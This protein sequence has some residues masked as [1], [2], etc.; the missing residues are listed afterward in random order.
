M[1]SWNYSAF[2]DKLG[3]TIEYG[4][5]MG[6]P[7]SGKSTLAQVLKSKID[8]QIISMKGI[9]DEIRAGMKNEEGEPVD[10]ETEVPITEVEKKVMEMINMGKNS[11]KRMKWV[12]D[13]YTH[14]DVEYF[15]N[16]IEPLGIPS[17]LLCLSADKKYLKDRFCKKNELEEFPADNEEAIDK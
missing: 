13:G 8:Y 16:F 7:N 9:A 1:S 11:N 10:P 14:T 4:I 5:V 15:Y 17:F 12:F 6:P 3:L 2:E